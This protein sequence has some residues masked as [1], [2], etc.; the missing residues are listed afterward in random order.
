MRKSKFLSILFILAF[1]TGA[2]CQEGFFS[3]SLQTNTNFFI[4]DPK[5]G[6]YN[7]PQYDNLKVGT[8]AWMNLNYTNEKYG[9]DIGAR[10]DFFL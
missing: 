7:L 1:C 4:R 5:I 2:K 9:L 6:A 10:F 3:G 8:D